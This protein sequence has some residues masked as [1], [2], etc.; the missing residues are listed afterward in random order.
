MSDRKFDEHDRNHMIGV[1]KNHFGVSLVRVAGRRKWLRDNEG[2]N[3]WVLGGYKNW[4]GI[5]IKM[6]QAEVEAVNH[7]FIAIALRKSSSLKIFVGD[8]QQLIKHRDRL[9]RARRTTGDYQFV[10]KQRG[11][12]LFVDKVPSMILDGLP[13]V[14]YRSDEKNKDIEVAKLK[15]IIQSLPVEEHQRL[16]DALRIGGATT[17]LGSTTNAC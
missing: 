11:D 10:V 3:Y 13:E 5:P 7:G 9:S 2:R 6:M 17:N 4:H 12:H 1:I 16:L 14:A 15:K 8:L